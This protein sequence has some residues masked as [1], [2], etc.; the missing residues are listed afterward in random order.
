MYQEL[1]TES[2]IDQVF[3]ECFMPQNLS[4]AG[5]H[6][7]IARILSVH[8]VKQDVVKISK[9]CSSLN[10]KFLGNEVDKSL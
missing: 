7:A 5:S 6:D 9:N 10:F 8:T 4:T 2:F 1:S 3:V